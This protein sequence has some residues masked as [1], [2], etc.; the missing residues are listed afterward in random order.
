MKLTLIRGVSGSGKT[1][2]ADKMKKKEPSLI[3]VAAD[4]FFEIDEDYQFNMKLLKA[5]HQYCFGQTFFHLY[6]G[7]NVAVTN[8]FT[9]RWEIGPYIDLAKDMCIE[10]EV[11]EPTTKWRYDA[12]ILAEKNVH[13]LTE[14]MIGK[15]LERWEDTKDILKY[16]NK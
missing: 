2:L 15:M 14:A 12:K 8:T 1:T 5:A 13:G 11:V 6:R 9:Q 16:F 7:N 3:I 4:H 10:W